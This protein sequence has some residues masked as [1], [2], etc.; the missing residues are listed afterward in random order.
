MPNLLVRLVEHEVLVEILGIEL[1]PLRSTPSGEMNAVGDVAHMVL[2][3]VVSLP[4]ASEHL[5]GDLA[6][7]PADAVDFLTGVAGKG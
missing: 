5:L 6:V 4:D 7:Q 3:G 2:L 1:A